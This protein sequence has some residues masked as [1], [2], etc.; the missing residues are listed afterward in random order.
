MKKE[1]YEISSITATAEDFISNGFTVISFG[2]VKKVLMGIL[3]DEETAHEHH[4]YNYPFT[5]DNEKLNSLSL[6]LQNIVFKE[7]RGGGGKT[8]IGWENGESYLR[9]H[10]GIIYKWFK[11]NTY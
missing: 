8:V 5:N 9:Y 2:Q 11:D 7:S 10:S 6:K 1:F 4:L 3:G